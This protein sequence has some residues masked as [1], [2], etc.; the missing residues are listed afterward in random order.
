MLF[1]AAV[2]VLASMAMCA[3][4]ILT[5][6]PAPVVPIVVVVCVGAPLFS[7]WDAPDAFARVRSDRWRRRALATLRRALDQLPEIEHPLGH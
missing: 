1:F 6:A 5:P 7:A 4:A 3:A 2:T